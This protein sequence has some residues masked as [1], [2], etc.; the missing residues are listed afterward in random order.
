MSST[1]APLGLIPVRTGLTGAAPSTIELIGGIQSGYAS[2]LYIGQPVTMSGGYLVAATTGQDIWGVFAGCKYFPAGTIFAVDGYW[3]A[4]TTVTTGSTIYAY[5]WL[6]PTTT[7][8]IQASGSITQSQLNS[9]FDFT[10]A[11]IGTGD[12]LSGS[13]YASMSTTANTTSGQTGQLRVTN[14]W[15]DQNNA[16][17]DSYTWVEVQIARLQ[18]VADKQNNT[19]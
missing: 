9:T 12:S 13:S 11:A 10:T 7:Y 19:N 18:T 15:D 2:N 4:S 5:V 1:L 8:R 3:P 17:G 14:L 6:D 16:W